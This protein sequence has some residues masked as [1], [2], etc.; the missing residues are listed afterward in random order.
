VFGGVTMGPATYFRAASKVLYL[1]MVPI[2]IVNRA[3]PMVTTSTG[4][5]GRILLV[6]KRETVV[7]QMRL[8]LRHGDFVTEV[9][10]DSHTA[11]RVVREWRPHVLVVDMDL[12]DGRVLDELARGPSNPGRVAV[13]AV[14]PDNTLE[15]R[16]AAYDRGANDFL[17]RPLMP[18]ELLAKVLVWTRNAA[19]LEIRFSPTISVGELEIDVRHRRVGV[20]DLEIHLTAVEE[21]LLY[22]LAGNAGRVLSRQEILDAVW[23]VEFVGESNVVDRHVRSLRAKLQDSPRRSRYIATIPGKGYRFVPVTGERAA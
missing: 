14:V 8:A 20:G 6:T 15:S 9:A 12:D 13:I 10:S 19:R 22:L 11:A 2:G 4:P 5:A 18:S 16:L 21:A 1:D 7:D 23:S 3:E 17:S